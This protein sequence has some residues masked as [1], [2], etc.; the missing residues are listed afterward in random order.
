MAQQIVHNT[1]VNYSLYYN[2][3]NYFKTIM[4]N[5]PSIQSVTYGDIDSIDDKQYTEY[6]LG[7][8]LIT[9]N[10]AITS[11]ITK[12]VTIPNTK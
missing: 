12:I 10:A 4:K 2:V 6:P 11:A 9:K 8:V 7:N 3:L 5:H 1:G